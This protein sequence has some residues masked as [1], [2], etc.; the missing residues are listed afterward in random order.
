MMDCSIQLPY[1]TNQT[2]Y[3]SRS[4]LERIQSMAGYDSSFSQDES[5]SVLQKFPCHRMPLLPCL[6][7]KATSS[8]SSQQQE[9]SHGKFL[10]IYRK[11]NS[12]VSIKE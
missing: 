2:S 7:R 6:N 10:D 5:Q 9:H 11:T 3:Y 8:S 12:I 1:V 4:Q